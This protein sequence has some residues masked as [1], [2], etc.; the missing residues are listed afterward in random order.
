MSDLNAKLFKAIKTH[1]PSATIKELLDVGADANVRDT[2]NATPLHLALNAKIAELLI[3]HGANVNAQDK[4]ENTPLHFRYF[5]KIFP[6]EY[7]EYEETEE[8]KNYLKQQLHIAKVLIEHGAD[9]NAKNKYGWTPL[10]YTCDVDMAKLLVEHGADVNAKDNREDT[11]LHNPGSA[12]MANFL[13]EH[14]ADLH[15]R[16]RYFHNTPLSAANDP[17]IAEVLIAHGADVTDKDEY[18]DTPLHRTMFA[19]VAEVFITIWEA[20]RCLLPWTANLPN[21]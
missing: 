12:D 5:S 8:M 20:H 7:D 14:G 16:N 9:V 10:F 18:W 19:E 3:T 13:I 11:P 4:E 21:F 2:D 17:D 6:C 1:Q 15:A